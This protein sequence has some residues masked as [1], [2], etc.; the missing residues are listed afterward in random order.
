[1][2]EASLPVFCNRQF[3]WL[4]SVTGDPETLSALSRQIMRFYSQMDDRR[5]YQ[6]MLDTQEDLTL[7]SDS[8]RYLM[9]KYICELNPST[10]LEVGCGSGRVY[11]QLRDYGFACA[12]S[13]IEV[14]EH[15]I[16]QNKQQH[17]EAV[18]KCAEVYEIPFADSTFDLCYSL[19]VLEHLVYPEKA[20]REMLRVLKP[21]GRLVLVFPDFVESGRFASQ[22]LGL[23]PINSAKEKLRSGRVVD[24]VLSLYDSRIRLPRALKTATRKHGKFPVNLSPLCLSYPTVMDADV[25]AIYI[26][27]KQEVQEW[28][29]SNGLDVEYPCGTAGEFAEQAFMVIKK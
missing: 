12:Y 3:N 20:L 7:T 14:A 13:G 29:I 23:S 15:L 5:S 17:P 8:V 11:R 28:A 2:P 18:W 27:S 16:A 24:A 19:Y 1:M 22:L 4:S 21:N 9:P 26:A 6:E 10:V 25:D